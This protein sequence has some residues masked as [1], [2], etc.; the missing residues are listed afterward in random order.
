[1]KIFPRRKN[2]TM[3]KLKKNIRRLEEMAESDGLMY[4]A[5]WMTRKFKDFHLFFKESDQLTEEDSNDWIKFMAYGK[6]YRPNADF[7]L[8]NLK[9][10]TPLMVLSLGRKWL[11]IY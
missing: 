2:R 8:K 5:G 6:L 3:K 7:L 11:L 1:M 9:N 4:L 10:T